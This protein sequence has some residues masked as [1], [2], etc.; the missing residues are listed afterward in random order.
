MYKCARVG[1]YMYKC[2]HIDLP[3][4]YNKYCISV[5]VFMC[6]HW[7]TMCVHVRV[8]VWV[9]TYIVY[10]CINVDFAMSRRT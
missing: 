6:A 10:E 7:E 1:V 3:C 2:M 5:H 4:M 8:H 9:S